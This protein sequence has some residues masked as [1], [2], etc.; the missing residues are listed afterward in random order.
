QFSWNCDHLAALW[1][2][3]D[4]LPGAAVDLARAHYSAFMAERQDGLRIISLNTDMIFT[5]TCRANYFNYINLDQPDNSGMLHFLTD[6]LQDAE[7]AGDRVWTI[8][9]VL[10]GW[11][12][13]NPLV[14]PTDR[15]YSMQVCTARFLHPSDMFTSV[16]RYSPHVI[17]NILFG[18]THEDQASIFYANNVT[19]ISAEN[20]LTTSWI[21]PSIT[22][23]TNLNSGFRMY[24]V[25]SATF[26]IMKAYTYV[27]SWRADVNTFKELDSQ[28]EFGPTFTFEY[29]TRDT[30]GPSVAGWTDSDPLN[31]TFWHLVTEAM[32]ANSSSRCTFN[33]LQGKT[34]VK[35]PV[36]T[37]ACATSQM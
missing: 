2:H 15:F 27:S 22:P 4:W 35:T 21:A 17:A 18:H 1:Q 31:A 30:Y 14:N 34:S 37:G 5:E 24:E 36:C 8:G 26:D 19:N 28:I 23:L 16:D 20:A 25:D 29:S 11:D 32:E 9:H 7:D 6:E 3:E 10:S 33:T 12:G 13:S